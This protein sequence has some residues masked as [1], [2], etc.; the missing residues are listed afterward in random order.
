LDVLRKMLPAL[1]DHRQAT[2]LAFACECGLA[3]LQTFDK[4]MVA[5]LPVVESALQ[6]FSGLCTVE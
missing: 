6:A 3:L 2:P 1:K 4:S 5:V